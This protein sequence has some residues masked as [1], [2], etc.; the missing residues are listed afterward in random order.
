MKNSFFNFFSF[1]SG[2]LLV[3]AFAPFNFWWLGFICPALFLFCLL[4]SQMSASQ[5][6][7]RGFL[8]GLG[9]F[10]VGTSWI[11][12]S[13]HAFGNAS[14]WLAGLITALFIGLMASYTGFIG[15]I[16]SRFFSNK[17]AFSRCCLIFP[18][19][20]MLSEW[21][22]CYLFTG[23]PWLALGY[24]QSASIF[25]ML[26]PYVSVFGVSLLTVWFSG[27]LLFLF[28]RGAW[29]KK[30][31]VL[32]TAAGINYGLFHL[33]NT[34]NS[35][36]HT[37]ANPIKIAMIQGNIS[38]SMKWDNAEISNTINTYLNLTAPYWSYDLIIWPEASV[39]LLKSQASELL[40]ELDEKAKNS[41]SS[42]LVGIP[43]DINK[44]IYNGILALGLSNGDYLKRHPV[45]FGEYIPLKSIFARAM[46]YF[47]I[48]MSDLSKGPK[49]QDPI[50]FLQKPIATFVCYE[51]AYPDEVLS[52]SH[53]S[54]FFVTINDDSWFGDSLAQPQQIQ[55]AQWRS[56][57]TGR[58]MLYVSNTGI[59]AIINQDGNIVAS[60]PEN[61]PT[62]LTGTITPVF[63]NTPFMQWGF[64]PVILVSSL[65][66]VLG[67]MGKR[68][69]KDH[70]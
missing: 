50:R 62:V 37:E 68:L 36:T 52:Q 31:M 55:M 64:Y 19:L 10:G 25:K 58:P 5:G 44:N 1:F 12:I 65:L 23:F 53:N 29:L 46:A 7:M 33:E 20:W 38:Q 51:V 41:Q 63:G 40:N 30:M 67:V 32:L 22:H 13:I 28:T 34:K 47:D 69:K 16:F 39:P 27:A 8:F 57:E 66:F 26:A 56:L 35:F 9:K 48:P 54:Q 43:I 14:W 49:K 70:S 21:L 42:L 18:S 3:F 24:S 59:T 6:F 2:A 4:N 15:L 45:P 61:I 11:Y 60:A 17:T